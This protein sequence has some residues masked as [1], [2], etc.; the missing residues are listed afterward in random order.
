MGPAF[1]HGNWDTETYTMLFQLLAFQLGSSKQH[2]VI[3][4]DD[5]K[6]LRAAI[7]RAFP[8]TKR[9]VCM[10]H[11]KNKVS[12]YLKDKLGLDSHQRKDVTDKLFGQDGLLDSHNRL[13]F[14][15]SVE[16]GWAAVP[17]F[18]SIHSWS[19]RWNI[20]GICSFMLF[21]LE[22]HFLLCK[23]DERAQLL[24]EV[25]HIFSEHLS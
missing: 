18:L 21:S 22:S 15:W 13:T 14:N 2:L 8:D 5:E 7:S 24:Q 23:A 4:G 17:H 6:A 16:R 12:D 9:M 10:R 20:F 11:L 19:K 25:G 1:L 3:G